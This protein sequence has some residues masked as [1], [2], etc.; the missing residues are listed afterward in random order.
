MQRL[1]DL[2]TAE[3][4]DPSPG[5]GLLQGK[6]FRNLI[7]EFCAV[8]RIED[9]RIPLSISAFDFRTLSTHVIR[10]GSISEAVYASCCV[11]LLFQPLRIGPSVYFD[12]GIGDR[13][14]LAGLPAE[15]RILYHHL[16]SNWPTWKKDQGISN[17]L[18]DRP[19]TIAFMANHLASVGPFSLHRG[20]IAFNQSRAATLKALEQPIRERRIVV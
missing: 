4:W 17:I 11:P 9:C 13:P 7:A 3:F 18:K 15:N 19:N 16:K 1:F 10:Q 12:G 8:E 20:K 14:A 2:R 6:L 5:F